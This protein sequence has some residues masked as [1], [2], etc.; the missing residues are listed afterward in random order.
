MEEKTQDKDLVKLAEPPELPE[1]SGEGFLRRALNRTRE[2]FR[3]VDEAITGRETFRNIEE[4]FHRQSELNESLVA[5]L[6]EALDNMETL[7]SRLDIEI[8]ALQSES[9]EQRAMFERTAAEIAKSS[10]EIRATA[11]SAQHALESAN[12]RH[13]E[14][15][16]QTAGQLA[17]WAA[18]SETMKKDIEL[19][20]EQLKLLQ[21][22]F[23]QAFVTVSV[24]LLILSILVVIL[25]IKAF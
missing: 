13:N 5:R 17:R 1:K 14:I 7:R 4:R 12:E 8:R 25:M 24:A 16:K 11:D 18:D 19:M 9:S 23:K 2:A 10:E 3:S 20:Q 22:S 15:Q 21:H 6:G